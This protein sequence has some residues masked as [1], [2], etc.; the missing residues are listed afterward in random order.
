[1]VVSNTDAVVRSGRR[2]P[3][4]PSAGACWYTVGGRG[5]DGFNAVL[6]V[7]HVR[8]AWRTFQHAVDRFQSAV[9]AC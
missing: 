3:K 6:S 1:M 7:L 4:K 9:V 2:C 8:R 5:D